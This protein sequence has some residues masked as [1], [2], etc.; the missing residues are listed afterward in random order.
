MTGMN[1]RR[2]MALL[3]DELARLYPLPADV[4]RVAEAA[5]L[6]LALVLLEG[7]GANLWHGVLRE[8]VLQ[9]RLRD[10]VEVALGDYPTHSG[11]HGVYNLL[12]RGDEHGGIGRLSGRSGRAVG[13]GSGWGDVDKRHQG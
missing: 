8:A 11:L 10:V 9:G 12:N 13:D 6:N 7:T 2:A 1:V 3:H 5:G 4:R